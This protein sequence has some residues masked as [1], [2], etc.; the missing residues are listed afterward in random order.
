MRKLC[1]ISFFSFSIKISKHLYMIFNNI[2]CYIFARCSKPER[3]TFRM[4]F[5]KKIGI[6]AYPQKQSGKMPLWVPTTETPP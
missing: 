3:F 5:T 2:I 6:S 4:I 1:Y